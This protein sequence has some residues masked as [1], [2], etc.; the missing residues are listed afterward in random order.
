MLGNRVTVLSAGRTVRLLIWRDVLRVYRDMHFKEGRNVRGL[1]FYSTSDLQRLYQA[2]GDDL[3]RLH[4][5]I[6]GRAQLVAVI[7]WRIVWARFGYS[8]LLFVS[9]T[10]AVAAAEGWEEIIEPGGRLSRRGGCEAE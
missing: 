9:L 2:T 4:D 6:M 7:R 8:L 5:G 3:I 1:E 10:A